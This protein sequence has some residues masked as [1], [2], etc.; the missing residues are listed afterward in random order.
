[1]STFPTE[2]VV[3]FAIFP[4]KIVSEGN[5]HENHWKAYARHKQQKALIHA[6]LL[7][8]RP[9]ITLPCKI[10]LTRIA[11]RKL[12]AHDNLRFALKWVV[13]SLASYV[14]PDKKAGRADDSPQIEWIYEQ[15]KGLPK[16]YALQI[17]ITTQSLDTKSS[18]NNCN[19]DH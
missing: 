4:I 13:D 1:M 15:K 7:R 3:Y 10:Y 16:E 8:D 17:T 11:P 19:T 9:Q 18:Q 2:S 6:Y 5:I 12:D 14:F